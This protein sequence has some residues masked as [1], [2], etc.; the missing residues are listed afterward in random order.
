MSIDRDNTK[1]T[2][3]PI[4]VYKEDIENIVDTI[5]SILHTD[6]KYTLTEIPS[7]LL[8]VENKCL[9]DKRLL[10]DKTVIP[11]KENQTVLCDKGYK[12]LNKVEIQ[13]INPNYVIPQG[14]LLIT[15]NGTVSCFGY[16]RAIVKVKNKDNSENS[17]NENNNKNG[18]LNVIKNGQYHTKNIGIVNVNIPNTTIKD[19]ISG[20]RTYDI[21]D[22]NIIKLNPYALAG[23]KQDTLK[24][25]LP[26]CTTLMEGCLS[27]SKI[28]TLNL[29]N[30]DTLPKNCFYGSDFISDNAINSLIDLIGHCTYFCTD[31]L[32]GTNIGNTTMPLTLHDNKT[33]EPYALRGLQGLQKVIIDCKRIPYGLLE[34]CMDLKYIYITKNVLDIQANNLNQLPF[35]NCNNLISIYV[36]SD[37]DN[38]QFK[39]GYFNYVNNT[40]IIPIKYNCNMSEFYNII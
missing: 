28:D 19:I 40:T 6:K 4:I 1:N 15:E 14:D 25:N 5:R 34:N 17:N 24:I 32:N 10:Q 12:G 36:E 20:E 18:I 33:L 30:I 11:T 35:K 3:T 22:T 27:H 31:C 21:S 38:I 39:Q 26:N 2:K 7:A 13:A 9:I 37:M 16:D 8:Q 29:G 23:Y